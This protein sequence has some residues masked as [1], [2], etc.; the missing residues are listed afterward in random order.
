MT[1]VLRSK[2]L[3]LLLPHQPPQT[4]II[5]HI[6]DILDAILDAIAAL[7]QDIVLEVQNLESGVHVFDELA[8]LQWA[9][10]VA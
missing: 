5:H 9:A 10:V 3:L 6:L 1:H 4:K 2:L 8:D 7:A